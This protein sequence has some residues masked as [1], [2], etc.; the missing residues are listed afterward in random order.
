MKTR[1]DWP[2]MWRQL[3]AVIA[4]EMKRNFFTK[5]ALWMYLLAFAPS[6][7][8]MIHAI[9]D[10]GQGINH[11]QKDTQVFS[12]IFQIFYMRLGIFFGCL[13]VFTWIYRG[14]VV[15]KSLHY[16]FLAP[17]RREVLVLGKFI[18]GASICILTFGMAV[19]FSFLLVYGHID[20]GMEF[21]TN[22]PGRQHLLA[23]LGITVLAVLGYGAI[24][25]AL[26]L[27]FKNPIIPGAVV[28]G[29]ETVSAVMPPLMQKFSV[30]YYLK[31]LCPVMEPGRGLMALFTVVAEPVSPWIAVPGLVV[32]TMAVLTFACWRVKT[33]EINY[34]TE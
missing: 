22:G 9:E 26:A 21:V 16:Y 1:L 18:A 25:L 32:L 4:L 15:E 30:T 2:V 12:Y 33:L 27:I 7:I 6:V 17:M 14:E 3:R 23:Y 13:G 11:V 31:F 24:F 34:G 5:R 10:G 20:R 19:W 8:I 29:W 28:L